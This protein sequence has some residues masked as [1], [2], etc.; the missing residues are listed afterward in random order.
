MLF[1]INLQQFFPAAAD[2]GC[3]GVDYLQ[4]ICQFL[5]RFVPVVL[6]YL[7]IQLGF[8]K[9]AVFFVGKKYLAPE[10]EAEEKKLQK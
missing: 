6:P 2:G 5:C 10:I 7:F 3:Q 1:L 9:G 8:Q 4:N